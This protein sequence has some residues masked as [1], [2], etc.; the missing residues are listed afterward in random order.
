VAFNPR[1]VDHRGLA[2]MRA[3]LRQDY[4]FSILCS[5]IAAIIFLFGMPAAM[6]CMVAV[7]AAGNLGIAVVRM[8]RVNKIEIEQAKVPRAWPPDHLQCGICGSY[9][10]DGIDYE[11]AGWEW[12]YGSRAHGS[13]IAWVWP[14]WN[15]QRS[16]TRRED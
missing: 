8:S 5:I 2:M 7:V 15:P 12:Y 10:A 11:G 14:L 6:G 16:I 9:A 13:C 4:S 1:T 3:Q